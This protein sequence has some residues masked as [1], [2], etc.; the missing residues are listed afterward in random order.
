M[1]S[2]QERRQLDD[3]EHDLLC[4]AEFVAVI[5]DV[6]YGS[7]RRRRGLAVRLSALVWIVA[8]IASAATSR[9]LPDRRM[10]GPAG[11]AGVLRLG[12]L[13][14]APPA[15]DARPHRIGIAVDPGRAEPLGPHPPPARGR[16]DQQVGDGLDEAGRAADVARR[17]EVGRPAVREPGAG[18]RPDV[19]RQPPARAGVHLDTS[20]PVVAGPRAQ[21]VGVVRLSGVRTE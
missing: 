17:L 12:R 14:R 19:G 21:L 5:A 2:E 18:M 10:P 4:D 9:P 7:P 8:V 20:S 11:V 16:R 1:L 6:L 3:I 15:P 13:R